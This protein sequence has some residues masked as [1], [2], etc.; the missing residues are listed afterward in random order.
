MMSD[1]SIRHPNRLK[2]FDYTQNGYYFVTICTHHREHFFGEVCEETMVLNAYGEIAKKCWESL[3]HHYPNCILDE[4]VIM[5]NHIHG[6]IVI[7]NKENLERNGYKPFPTATDDFQKTHRLSEM[8]RGFKTF[9]SKTINSKFGTKQFQWQ[10]SFY[11]HIIRDEEGLGNIR[12][13]IQ[14]NPAKWESEK[15]RNHL[16]NL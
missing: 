8:I 7:K 1:Y 3:P 10:K 2:G 14:Q 13:Y 6:I 12:E 11:D 9:S 16:T 4:Y 15:D 5:P